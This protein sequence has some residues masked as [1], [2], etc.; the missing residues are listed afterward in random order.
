MSQR[1]NTKVCPLD[2]GRVFV[3]LLGSFHPQNTVYR[4]VAI[5]VNKMCDG[6]KKRCHFLV[7][8]MV[9]LFTGEPIVC[10][11]LEGD[12]AGCFGG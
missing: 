2:G 3:C 10:F 12:E 11:H 7:I 5:E 8:L 6:A 9:K 4:A 1:C